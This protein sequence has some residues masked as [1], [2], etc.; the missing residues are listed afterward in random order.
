MMRLVLAAL[1]SALGLSSASAQGTYWTKDVAT[2][3][4]ATLPFPL[5]SKIPVIQPD[6]SVKA[7]FAVHSWTPSASGGAMLNDASNVA[8]A[9]TPTALA[10][11]VAANASA[12]TILGGTLR[13]QSGPYIFNDGAADTLSIQA[14]PGAL[15]SGTDTNLNLYSQAIGPTNAAWFIAT[16]K[17]TG[18]NEEHLLVGSRGFGSH[19]AMTQVVLGAGVCRD[20]DFQDG[21][22]PTVAWSMHC[23]GGGNPPELRLGDFAPITQTTPSDGDQRIIKLDTSLNLRVAE[24]AAIKAVVNY[25]HFSSNGSSPTLSS[26]GT[27]PSITIS[28]DVK[29]LVTAGSG[30]P[31]SCQVAFARAYDNTPVVIVTGY[32]VSAAAINWTVSVSSTSGFT[33]VG[34]GVDLSGASFQYWVIQ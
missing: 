26:C 23:S 32:G 10:N 20:V 19:Y 4:A 3:P 13:V 5:T 34:N 14:L 6:S 18:G 12:A 22:W 24:G 31:T 2:A 9:G 25:S 7:G 1:L 30:G 28:T 11:I 27:S 29:G 17:S 15:P 33:V 21:V 8:P 16:P